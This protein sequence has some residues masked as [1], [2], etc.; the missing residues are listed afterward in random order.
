MAFLWLCFETAG[1]VCIYLN[2]RFNEWAWK[3]RSLRSRYLHQKLYAEYKTRR[4]L[5][6]LSFKEFKNVGRR[7]A[8]I[9]HTLK[10]IVQ[11][12]GKVAVRG[13]HE[14]H[15]HLRI[16][17]AERQTEQ[18]RKKSILSRIR[19]KKRSSVYQQYT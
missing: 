2:K 3:L 15:G 16:Q 18:N 8:L 14:T 12:T 7:R 1:I 9:S 6:T 10:Q 13:K 4:Q 17:R 11:R 5:H 19:W